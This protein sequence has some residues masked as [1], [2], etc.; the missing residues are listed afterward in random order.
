LDDLNKEDEIIDVKLPRKDFEI[1]RAMIRKQEA[2]GWLGRYITNVLLIAVGGFITLFT[3]W[4]SIK[5]SLHG[6]IK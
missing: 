3:F 1:M 2:L 6:I 5:N 4:D